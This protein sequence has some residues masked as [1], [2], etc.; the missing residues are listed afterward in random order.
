MVERTAPVIDTAP[1]QAFMA[2]AMLVCLVEHSWA[3]LESWASHLVSGT[4][5]SRATAFERESAWLD[6]LSVLQRYERHCG[7][8][9]WD[10]TPSGDALLNAA[11]YLQ[12]GG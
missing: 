7:L 11:F 6:A 2:R 10:G 5:A 9:E 8:P 3:R 1:W 12:A 4:G